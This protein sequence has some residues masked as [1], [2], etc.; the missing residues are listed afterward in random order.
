MVRLRGL[1]K[2]PSNTGIAHWE[3][4]YAL[5]TTVLRNGNSARAYLQEILVIVRSH[6]L[7]F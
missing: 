3:Y 5:S 7:H 1:G 4:R 2:S 6:S